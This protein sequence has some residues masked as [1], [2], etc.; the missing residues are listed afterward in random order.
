M[1]LELKVELLIAIERI[2][3]LTYFYYPNIT[4][5]IIGDFRGTDQ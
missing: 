4:G 5:H 2:K 3:P 1:F